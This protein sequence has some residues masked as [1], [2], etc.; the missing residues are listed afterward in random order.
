MA[1]SDLSRWQH[2]AERRED[3]RQERRLALVI[4][5]CAAGWIVAAVIVFA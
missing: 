4:L 1:V 2:L 3:L 5:A